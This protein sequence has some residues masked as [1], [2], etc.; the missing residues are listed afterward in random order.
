[1][2]PKNSR[3]TKR[4]L[5]GSSLSSNYNKFLKGQTL[6]VVLSLI[7]LIGVGTVAVGLALGWGDN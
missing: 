4:R 2:P 5:Y 6:I 3:S 1:M 7:A